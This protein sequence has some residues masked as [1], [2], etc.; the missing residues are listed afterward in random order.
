MTDK[1]K[2]IVN[3]SLVSV[4]VLALSLFAWFKPTDKYSDTE[5]RGLKQFP[6][7]NVETVLNGNFMNNFEGYVTDQ[8]PMRESFRTLKAFTRLNVFNQNDNNDIYFSNGFIS[9]LNYPQNEKNILIASSKFK[10]IYE[11]YL[12]DNNANVYL[13]LIPDKNA[14]LAEDIGAPKIDYGDFA[15]KL[16]NNTKDFATYIDIY[17]LL[18]RDDYYKTDTHW[19][20]EKIYDVAQKIASEMGVTL[21]AEYTPKK[22][23]NDF[24]GVYYGQYAMPIGGEDIY[25]M[26][27]PLFENCTT[28]NHE[29]GTKMPV[30]NLEKGAGRDPYEMYLSGSLSLITIDNPSATTEK[31]LI[32]FRDSFGSSISPYFAEGY[33]KVTL[34]DIRYIA[35]SNLGTIFE[36]S[37]IS[38]ENA[39]VLFL[40]STLVLNGSATLLK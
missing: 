16:Q 9:E 20:Q 35:S 28:I 14:F 8:F 34:V 15:N 27:N 31:E 24:F 13:S 36:Q 29:K 5:R 22:L 23:E 3:I 32:I 11:T 33:S 38:F 17:P 12:K 19:R 39:D 7:L 10:S 18:E 4:L 2:N 21:K 25:Y 26:D 37:G 40:Y 30:Y 6:T 1:I